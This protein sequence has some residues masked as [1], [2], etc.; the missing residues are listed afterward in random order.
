MK[1]YDISL[2]CH[3]IPE[4][5]FKVRNKHLPFCA[6]CLGASIG[7]IGAAINFFIGPMLP[8]YFAPI[9]MSI[10]FIDWVFQNKYKFY[11][12]NFSRLIT[13]VVGGYA[14]GIIIWFA[15]NTLIAYYKYYDFNAI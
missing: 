15:V 10:M 13:G 12:S 14:V 5:C 1:L 7:H 2:G 4:R 8:L 11:H 9:G 3:G 6:R